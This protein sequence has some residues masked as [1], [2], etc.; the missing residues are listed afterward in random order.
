LKINARVDGK[1]VPLAC[2]NDDCEV[3]WLTEDLVNQ[4]VRDAMNA[5][6]AD[7]EWGQLKQKP[8]HRKLE[9]RDGNPPGHPT[10]DVEQ[11]REFIDLHV[12]TKNLQPSWLFLAAGAMGQHNF[13]VK[14]F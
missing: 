5:F 9:D 11:C 6:V 10:N 2:I 12:L 1:L 13:P 3:A 14:N 7:L 4:D 8:G